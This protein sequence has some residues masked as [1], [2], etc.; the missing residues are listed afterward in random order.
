[1]GTTLS[2]YTYVSIQLFSL[3]GMRS[4]PLVKP[5]PGLLL[6]KPADRE[7]RVWPKESAMFCVTNT[8][9]DLKDLLAIFHLTQFL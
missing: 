6:C 3:G 1:M 5:V 2:P 4:F 7:T 8:A 9:N